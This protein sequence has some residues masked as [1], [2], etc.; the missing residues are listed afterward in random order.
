MYPKLANEGSFVLYATKSN[1][2]SG[3]SSITPHTQKEPPSS[4]KG[5]VKKIE[6]LKGD[7]KEVIKEAKAVAIMVDNDDLWQSVGGIKKAVS[8]GVNV[9][10]FVQGAATTILLQSPHQPSLVV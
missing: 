8:Y 3:I 2:L 4:G 1:K 9:V 5:N 7:I 6:G 10:E